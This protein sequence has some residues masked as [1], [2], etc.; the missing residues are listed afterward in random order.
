M[1]NQIGK[2]ERFGIYLKIEN[3]C[4]EILSLVIEASFL[5]KSDKRKPLEKVRIKVEILKQL[6]R[7]CQEQDIIEEK[8]YFSL[9]EK[10]QEISKMIA[11]WIKYVT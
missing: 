7:L 3:I 9:Q 4:L 11:G 6:I 2:R 5:P 1:G 10:L 8:K